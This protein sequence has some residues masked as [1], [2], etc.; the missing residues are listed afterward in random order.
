MMSAPTHYSLGSGAI[1]NLLLADHERPVAY[2]MS[3]PPPVANPDERP[4][5]RSLY[6]HAPQ[7]RRGRAIDDDTEEFVDETRM[8]V[9]A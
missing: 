7:G 2:E 1:K 3:P 6:V 5:K 8:G 9:D 4:S